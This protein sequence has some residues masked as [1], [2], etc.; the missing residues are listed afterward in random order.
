ML[1]RPEDAG[2]GQ[3]VDEEAVALVGRDAAGA[4][5][6]LHQVALALERHHFGAH[7]GRGDLH[8]GCVGHVGGADRL[9]RADVLGDHRLENGGPAVVEGAVVRRRSS[10]CGAE[11]V[12]GVM[13]VPGTQVYRV[14]GRPVAPAR[15]HGG[16]PGP[17]GALSRRPGAAPR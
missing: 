6:G 3:V 4:G 14:P 10:V 11:S 9:G 8:P 2:L 1:G 16:A 13:G 7:G 15:R 5:V 12:V 17:I